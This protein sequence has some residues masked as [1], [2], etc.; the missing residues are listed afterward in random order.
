MKTAKI[1]YIHIFPFVL[2]AI[3]CGIWGGWIRLGWTFPFTGPAGKHGALMV[4]SF[5]GTLI[6][7]ERA[8]I[9]KKQWAWYVPLISGS[10]IFFILFRMDFAAYSLLTLGSLGLPVMIASLAQ[11]YD[12]FYLKVMLGGAL[13]WLTGNI[14][15]LVYN[16]YPLAVPWWMAFLLLTITSERLEISRFLPSSWQ[17]KVLLT[18]AL[19][20][21][22]VGLVVPF[23]LW[24][25]YISGAGM[26]LTGLWLL[27]YDMATKSVKKP[28]LSRFSGSLLLSGYGW[29]A[30]CGLTMMLG[31]WYGFMYDAA[32]HA[33]FIGFVFSMIFAHA[34][35]ILPGVAGFSFK[36]FSPYL[37]VWA[38]LLQT[39]LLTRFL[40]G[41]F[42]LDDWRMWGGIL[43][44]IA[45]LCFFLHI[46]LLSRQEMGR[47][48]RK[49]GDKMK[50]IQF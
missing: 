37:Y 46:G 15:L 47:V 11:K 26:I 36:P 28:G 25:R 14:I 33:F 38:I 3:L 6:C 35:I 18:M 31:N 7:L 40:G 42:E 44:G 19:I 34:P 8:A 9:L 27:K 4:G 50:R 1:N 48:N 20:L 13:C 12:E 23:H 22:I 10:S 32:L 17:K 43:N 45:I 16:S 39:S 41:L 49:L 24:G 30:I 5:L 29:L 21:F 2:L